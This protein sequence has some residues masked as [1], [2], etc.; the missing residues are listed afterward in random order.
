MAPMTMADSTARK[1][2]REKAYTADAS[3]DPPLPKP[4]A[5][6][7]RSHDRPSLRAMGAISMMYTKAPN[8]AMRAATMPQKKPATVDTTPPT[9]KKNRAVAKPAKMVKRANQLLRSSMGMRLSA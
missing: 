5:R 3:T 6:E 4:K 7:H 1:R 2:M 9:R 8:P